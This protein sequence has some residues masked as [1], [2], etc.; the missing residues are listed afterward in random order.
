MP[1]ST[2]TSKGQTTI[3]KEIREK[4]K[5][6]AGDRLEYVCEEEG[7]AL[8]IPI[9]NSLADLYGILPAKGK[10]VTLEDMQRAIEEEACSKL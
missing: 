3:P 2:L 5:L 6:K 8:L 7:K 9:R 4:L 10:R 1:R